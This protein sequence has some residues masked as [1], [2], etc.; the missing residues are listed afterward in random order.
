VKGNPVLFDQ[1]DKILLRV[2]AERRDAELRIGGKK[3]G[4]FHMEIGKIAPPAAGQ[5]D[6]LA[7]PV[8][9]FD[10]QYPAAA[11]PGSHGTHQTGGATADNNHI[12]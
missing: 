2:T 5:Q 1:L 7:H 4:G 11:L 3:P 10:H 8:G 9:V 6:F 12:K